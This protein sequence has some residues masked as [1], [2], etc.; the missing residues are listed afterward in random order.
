MTSLS[1]RGAY[2]ATLPWL[3]TSLLLKACTNNP[4]ANPT[5][6][7]TTANSG[8]GLKIAVVLPAVIT[9]KACNQSGYEGVNLAKQKLGAEIAYVENVAQ[10]DQTEAL[11]DFAQGHPNLGRR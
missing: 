2:P 6:T 8:E 10:A 11:T 3:T 7:P 9:G 5:S 1:I 4:N